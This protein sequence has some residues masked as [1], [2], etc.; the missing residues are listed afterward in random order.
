MLDEF[1]F[2]RRSHLKLTLEIC[3]A[4]RDTGLIPQNPARQGSRC[5]G[6]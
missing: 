4:G 2:T 6:L 3:Q 1:V 5:V